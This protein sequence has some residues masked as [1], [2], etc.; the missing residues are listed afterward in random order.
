M[1]HHKVKNHVLGNLRIYIEPAHKV[2][3][4]E[5]SLFRKIF[6]RSAYLHILEEAR[7]DGIINATVHNTQ[8]SYTA[9][10][11][12]VTFNA[13]GNNS[14]LAMVVELIDKRERLET[15]FLKHRELLLGKVV[16]YKEVEFW[17]IE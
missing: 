13:E 9:D 12:I 1:A 8:T 7:K 16:I 3:H 17:D 5:R 15:F 11:K 14:Q 4:G 10:G 6:P 2:R